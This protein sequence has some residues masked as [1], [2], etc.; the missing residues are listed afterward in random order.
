MLKPWL[1]SV[2]AACCLAFPATYEKV[3]PSELRPTFER[4]VGQAETG[5]Y[6]IAR[7]PR[8]TAFVTRRG[9]ELHVSHIPRK[10]S[11]ISSIIPI[12]FPGAIL[13]RP[14]AENPLRARTHALLGNDESQWIR[15]IPHFA[16]ARFPNAYPGVDIVF[17][18]RQGLVEFDFELSPGADPALVR[19]QF[20]AQRPVLADDG[21]ITVKAAGGEI[22][23]PAPIA[24]QTEGRTRHDVPVRFRMLGKQTAG[25]TVGRTNAALALTIDPAVSYFTYHG[26]SGTETPWGFAVDGA[27]NMYLGGITASANFPLKAG[28]S[29]TALRGRTDMF[30][31]EF[32][33]DGSLVYSTIFGGNSD[34]SLYD[35]AVDS[36]GSIYFCGSSASDNFPT[37][38]PIQAINRGGRTGI[39]AVFGKL[40]PA[41]AALVYSTFFGG[42]FDDRA[43]ACTLNSAGSL[44]V[45][46]YAISDT[47][48]TTPGAFQSVNR[49]PILGNGFVVKMAPA[50]DKADYATF[51]GGTTDETLR[52]IAVDARGNAYVVGDSWSVNYPTVGAMQPVNRGGALRQDAVITKINPTGT[53]LLWSTYFGG[54][55]DDFGYN[56]AVDANEDVYV[57]GVTD[58]V[59]NFPFSPNPMQN[60]LSGPSDMF[61]AKLTTNG[62]MLA[63]STLFGGTRDEVPYNLAV[64]RAG[65]LHLVGF[66]SSG[67]IRAVDAVQRENAGGSD[68]FLLKLAPSGTEVQMFTYMGGPGEEVLGGVQLDNS[69]RIY[70]AGSTTSTSFTPSTNAPQ[71]VNAG[72]RDAFVTIL[73]SSPAANPFTLS[74][75]RLTFTGAPG[76]AIARQQFQIRATAGVPQWTVA[77]ATLAGGNWLSVSPASGTGNGTI[78]V[79]V[80]TTGMAA[81]TYQGTIAVANVRLG[82]RKVVAVDLTIAGGGGN[83]PSNGIVSAATFAGGGVSPGLI[84]TIFGSAIGPAALTTAQ[85]SAQ[86]LLMNILAETR[87]LFDGVAAPLVYVS[88]TQLSAIVPYA[89]AGRTTTSVQV[90]YRGN[91]S[92]AVSVPV[93]ATAPGLFT[94]NSSGKGPGAILNQDSSVNSASN[95]ARKGDVVVLFGTGEGVTDPGGTD[96]ALAVS[97]FPKPRQPVTVRIG[98]KEAE[99]LYAGAA[100]GLVAGVIQINVKIPDDVES[101][102]QPVVV[103]IGAV[104][105]PAEVTVAVQ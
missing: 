23:L 55:G 61:I 47:L 76:A 49:S 27:G 75:T 63:Y 44:F 105:S 22:R 38:N 98:G 89:V 59:G 79:A 93:V 41:G 73:D 65:A 99:V 87:V 104:S 13:S 94:A 58:G 81:G 24:W 101:G 50:G 25:F 45:T 78:D 53:A 7:D 80:N 12:T 28:G 71:K 2:L 20:P 32:A 95:P 88:A 83:V 16:S 35:M 34:D 9:V 77:A 51:L 40:N 68:G 46:G 56:I 74:T 70:L 8:G 6:F 103:Q 31:S 90:E 5:V 100:P 72:G 3:I 21:A 69:G 42:N 39:D 48:P 1:C 54:G 43:Y 86:G 11:P 14:V 102:A 36:Q 15:D 17:H 26:G 18:A 97:V 4:N 82:E 29:Q 30:V 62:T 96:G 91:R 64:D 10:S 33:P 37:V 92:N 57:V 19:I 52:D 85:V 60:T 84:V 67:S 66:T